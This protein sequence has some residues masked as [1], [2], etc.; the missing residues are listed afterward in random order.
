MTAAFDTVDNDILLT[1]LSL[2]FGLSASVLSLL[3]SYLS[4]RALTVYIGSHSSHSSSVTTGVPQRSVLDHL[5]FSLYTTPLSYLLK[6]LQLSFHMYTDKTQLYLS[7][8]AAH[9]S[10]SLN[11]LSKVLDSVHL[12]LSS[13]YLALDPSKTE[14]LLIL[15]S[16][17]RTKVTLDTLYYAVRL[18]RPSS[19]ARNLRV[20]FEF[21]L[22]LTKHISSVCQQ[23]FHAVRILRQVRSSLDHNSAVLLA[24]SRLKLPRLF[25]LSILWSSSPV[26]SPSS[27]RP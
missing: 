18:L 20:T 24:N 12:W 25:Q 8:S 4:D 6:E 17:Q 16:Q 26:T 3:S 5:Q 11:C 9:S 10:S 15:T 1:R 22:S 7:L 14:Y 2:N 27:T 21:D 19:S 23:S 13:N